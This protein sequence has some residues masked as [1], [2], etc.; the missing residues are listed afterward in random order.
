MM[1]QIKNQLFTNQ[2]S[3]CG[4]YLSEC[5]AGHNIYGLDPDLGEG[6]YQ[7]FENKNRFLITSKNFTYKK[8]TQISWNDYEF[9][10]A[11]CSLSEQ[12]PLLGH[13]GQYGE[14][15]FEV[16]KDKPIR[17]IGITIMPGFYNEIL[18]TIP[19]INQEF[20]FHA[21]Q[22]LSNC[23]AFIEGVAIMQQIGNVSFSRTNT[24]YYEAKL[25]E[26]ICYLIDYQ[27][28]IFSYTEGGKLCTS[29]YESIQAVIQYLKQ[30][31]NKPLTISVCEKTACMS[32]SKLSVLFKQVTGMTMSTY[33]TAIR[34][35]QAKNLLL[36]S[37]DTIQEIALEVG[38]ENHSS[39]TALFKSYTG[40][41]PKDYRMHG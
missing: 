24:L 38:L 34:M 11:D 32:K 15:K 29:D 26:F 39:F 22:N 35:E 4:F 31:Y 2:L 37:N 19:D 12:I 10:H 3:G 16:I 36:H 14:Y 23:T 20:F 13:I 25:R 41:T 40:Y 27:T 21:F 1:K 17:S 18:R 33:L 5:I 7:V 30:N 9:L 6:F 8:N 28:R